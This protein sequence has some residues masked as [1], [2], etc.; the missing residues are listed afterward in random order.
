MSPAFVR[1]RKGASMI[2]FHVPN[3]SCSGC[4][5]AVTAA[6]R[7]VDPDTEVRAD[8]TR[9]EVVVEGTAD[10]AA[11]AQALRAAGFEGQRLST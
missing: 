11:L 5:R 9:R 2:R 7:S 4:V 1:E 3:M 8:L 6:L 10:P